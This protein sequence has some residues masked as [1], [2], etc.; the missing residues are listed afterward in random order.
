M[1]A[2]PSGILALEQ[3]E[4]R[5]CAALVAGDAEALASLLTDDLVHIHL[6]GQV[7]DKAGYVGGVRGK[8]SFQGIERGPLTIR[9][10]GDVAVMT[11]T[12]SQQLMVKATGTIHN[13]RAIATQTWLR[14]NG[15]WLQN[16]CHNSALPA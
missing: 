13:V 3:M 6:T 15:G 10:Y 16:T 9:L 1:T 2:Q 4:A 7:D 12:L 8:Y 5:R 11:G 14:R